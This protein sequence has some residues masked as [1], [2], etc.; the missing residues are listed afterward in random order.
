MST[1]KIGDLV[2]I[3]SDYGPYRAIEIGRKDISGRWGVCIS[4]DAYEE[5]SSVMI[6]GTIVNIWPLSWIE[7]IDGC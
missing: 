6:S 2:R 4:Y 5:V 7:V 1:P 3:R